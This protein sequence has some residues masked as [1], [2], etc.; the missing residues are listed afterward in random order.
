MHDV[1]ASIHH[2]VEYFSLGLGFSPSVRERRVYWIYLWPILF[3]HLWKWRTMRIN[4]SHNHSAN[5]YARFSFSSPPKLAT[6]EQQQMK[7]TTTKLQY[8]L[9]G[10][11]C[12]FLFFFSTIRL[13]SFVSCETSICSL[14]P[15]KHWMHS[16]EFW[17]ILFHFPLCV[18]CSFAL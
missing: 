1:G 4:R 13:W 15:V 17:L 8:I 9:R 7:K 10:D 3:A 5:L 18:C 11:F 6:N 2:F 12:F 16:V 14:V